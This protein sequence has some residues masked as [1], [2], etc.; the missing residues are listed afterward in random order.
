MSETGHGDVR[1]SEE[2][3]EARLAEYGD[4]VDRTSSFPLEYERDEKGDAIS[5]EA[6][7][8][9][10]DGRDQSI[11]GKLYTPNEDRKREL[12][13]MSPG[14]PGDGTVKYEERYVPSLTKS[15][16]T[17]FTARHP[18]L[19]VADDA[20]DTYVHCREKKAQ[21]GNRGQEYL[22]GSFSYEELG[23]E[24][25]TVMSVLEKN[26]DRV[27]FVGHSDGMYVILRSLVHLLEEKPEL[28]SK[29]GNLVSL[30]GVTGPYDEKILRKFL[31]WME[32][33]KL[34]RLPDEEQNVREFQTNVATFRGTDWSRFPHMSGMFITPTGLLGG[35]PD[36]Y[37]PQSS[38][39]DFADFIQGQGC[40]RVRV[41]DYANLR[42]D[43]EGGE[44][45]H[46]FNH[47]SPG[48]TTRWITGETQELLE[49]KFNKS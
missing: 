6:T 40:K 21:A 45:S 32:K 36:E 7:W 13:I 1:S 4:A 30:A 41:V 44:E 9:R 28:A 24:A 25:L 10:I 12:V 34:Y 31:Q 23:R 14:S 11:E 29:V 16:L 33:E 48:I 46:D 5:A 17:V 2:I 49:K 37:M 26:F 3:V 43:T 42:V 27:H 38:V 35:T 22:D 20:P 19:R 8:L 18:G 47:L 39:Q 15:G